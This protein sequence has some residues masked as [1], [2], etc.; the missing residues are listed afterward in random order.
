MLALL[1][2]ATAFAAN[3]SRPNFVF[4]LTD[5][6]DLRL[7]GFSDA[8]T[9]HG[10]LAAMPIVRQRLMGEGAQ[11]TNFFVNT[12]ICCPSRTE[13]FSG[14]YFHNVGPPS[15]TAGKCMHAD[16]S[17]ASSN[18]TGLFGT[19]TRHGYNTGVFGKVTNDQQHILDALVAANSA[20]YIDSPIASTP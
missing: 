15:D 16:T 14:R 4:V 20:T 5:D 17:F 2:S 18:T 6:Q 11:L 19:L 9:E 13:F 3:S 10:S 8:Y 12:P 7:D 1:A